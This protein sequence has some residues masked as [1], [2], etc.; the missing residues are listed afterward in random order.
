MHDPIHR[1]GRLAL[2]AIAVSSLW[3]ASCPSGDKDTAG[4]TGS[5]VPGY[6][7]LGITFELAD[8]YTESVSDYLDDNM[9]LV[10]WRYDDVAVSC[11]VAD[12]PDAPYYLPGLEGY[13]SLDSEIV[14]EVPA[15]Q[16][17]G[18]AGGE[19]YLDDDFDEEVECFGRIDII[20]V[21]EC[22]RADAAFVVTCN[23]IG[24]HDSGA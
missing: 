5:C 23:L 6:G 17:C 9:E 15:G 12:A 19:A 8:A 11:L 24:P 13:F 21:P 14:L 10:L 16:V 18:L 3:V 7:T 22:G 1:P 20:N 4:D 2:A